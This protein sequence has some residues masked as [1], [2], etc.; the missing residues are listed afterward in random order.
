MRKSKISS[1]QNKDPGYQTLYDCVRVHEC[2]WATYSSGGHLKIR[3]ILGRGAIAVLSLD[4]RLCN[5]SRRWFLIHLLLVFA[6]VFLVIHLF[7]GA[8]TA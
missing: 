5:F 7:T 1:R 3:T 8:K 2:R 6:V 4:R